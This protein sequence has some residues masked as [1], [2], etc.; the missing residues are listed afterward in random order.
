MPVVQ[1]KDK[2]PIAKESSPPWRKKRQVM[3]S[4]KGRRKPS[5]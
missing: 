5:R 3:G 2:L 4:V 1:I